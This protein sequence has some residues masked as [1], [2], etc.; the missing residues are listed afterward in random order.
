MSRN[1]YFFIITLY[2]CSKAKGLGSNHQ[3]LRY[4]STPPD[5][6]KRNLKRF[7]TIPSTTFLCPDLFVIFLYWIKKN[8]LQSVDGKREE[9]EE[10]NR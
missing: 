6:E 4:A 1:E 7:W 5:G 9:E 2:D 8:L 10:G 3:T